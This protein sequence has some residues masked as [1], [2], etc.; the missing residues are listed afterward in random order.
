MIPISH[1]LVVSQPDFLRQQLLRVFGRGAPKR[2]DEMS[3]DL[4]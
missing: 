4:C 3:P 1:L 2:T